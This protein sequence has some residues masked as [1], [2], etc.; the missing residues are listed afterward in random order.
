VVRGEIELGDL[1]RVAETAIGD[2]AGRLRIIRRV[3]RMEPAEAARASLRL[4]ITITAPSGQ[5]SMALR[6]G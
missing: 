3:I 6:C 4:S 1:G 5:S 2:H